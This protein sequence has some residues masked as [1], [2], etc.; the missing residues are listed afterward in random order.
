[1]Q[2]LIERVKAIILKPRE[3]WAVIK[4]EEVTSTQLMREYVMILAAIP[5]VAGFIGKSIV[6]M[7]IPFYGRY[8]FPLG[9]G[10]L[11][12]IV[13]Y[14]LSLVGVYV[15]A[16]VINFLATNFNAVKD[17]TKAFKVAAYAW[18]PA[19]I[20]GIFSLIPDLSVLGILGLYS[21]Y[22]IYLGLP[23]LMECPSEKALGYTVTIIIAVIVIYVLI[24]VI[25]GLIVGG[26]PSVPHGLPR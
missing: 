17:D 23:Y 21:L 6:G 15:V 24:G 20:A 14:I 3:T 1:M 7:K 11:W 26:F 4:E 18:T 19:F 2:N 22:L 5:A 25:T 10:L 16:K 8:H 13:E 9:R 12:V